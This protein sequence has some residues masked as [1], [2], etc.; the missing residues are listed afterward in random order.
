VTRRWTTFHDTAVSLSEAFGWLSYVDPK[1]VNAYREF[2]ATERRRIAETQP[3]SASSAPLFTGIAHGLKE[4][5][6]GGTT[7]AAFA[8]VIIFLGAMLLPTII[9][10][11][12][13]GSGGP[14]SIGGPGPIGIPGLSAMQRSK[15]KRTMADLRS[16]ASAIEAYATDHN[17]YPPAPSSHLLS[18]IDKHLSPTYTRRLPVTDGWGGPIFYYSWYD[19][20][21]TEKSTHT[22]A[23]SSNLLPNH[24]ALVTTGKDRVR[25]GWGDPRTVRPAQ[26]TSLDEDMV[27]R[28]GDFIRYPE[29][30][31]SQ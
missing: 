30:I 11:I 31:Q 13:G 6:I 4:A 5:F 29:G 16:V 1:V 7:A 14:S 18:D 23:T 19:G 2:R 20:A 22:S 9:S 17:G 3:R 10:G 26:T 12:M 28:D 24:Y 27:F 25:Q 21:G 8:L 15:Q